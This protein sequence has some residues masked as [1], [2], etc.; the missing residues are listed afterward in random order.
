MRPKEKQRSYKKRYGEKNSK[1]Q[2]QMI[3]LMGVVLALAVFVL[4]SLA[5]EI[6]DLDIA[7][8]SERASS[9]LPEF[10]N[11]KE[12]FGVSLNYN[13]VKNVSEQNNVVYYYGDFDEFEDAFNRTRDKYYAMELNHDVVFNGKLITYRYSHKEGEN[14]VYEV[15]V[16]L[17][18]D[19]GNTCIS[20]DVTYLIT[21]NSIIDSN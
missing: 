20:D 8:Q 5:A 18:L 13:V 11:V 10:I 1:E 2:A 17:S 4:G 9:L 7:I 14:Y 21:C 6:T 3:I 16:S 15:L 12:S 19:N